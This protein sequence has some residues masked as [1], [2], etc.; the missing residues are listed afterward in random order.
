MFSA[1]CPFNLRPSH[2]SGR[3]RGLLLVWTLLG[4]VWMQ[5]HE[6]EPPIPLPD[7]LFQTVDQRMDVQPASGAELFVYRDR[8]DVSSDE[9]QAAEQR[10]QLAQAQGD[11][12]LMIE[13]IRTMGQGYSVRA[14]YDRAITQFGKGL[15][16]A[17]RLN[18]STQ[19]ALLLLNIARIHHLQRELNL[20][21]GYYH[22]ALDM[23]QQIAEERIEANAITAIGFIYANLGFPNLAL[24]H[25][26]R[27]LDMHKRTGQR[28]GEATTYNCMGLAYGVQF[29]A[30]EAILLFQN[31]IRIN[32]QLGNTGEAAR[33]LNNLCD[34]HL[35]IQGLPEKVLPLAARS[36]RYA[37]ELGYRQLI[38][39]AADRL[40]EANRALGRA[41]PALDMLELYHDMERQIKT[42]ENQR[43]SL[44]FE[45][46]QKA[47][48]DSLAYL[49]RQ[50]E[51]ELGHQR[52]ISL[53]NY[54]LLGV[55]GL[56]ILGVILLRNRQRS[57][58]RATQQALALQKA[59][60]RRLTELDQAK[61]QLY[62]NITHE[63]RTPLTIILGMAKKV[64]EAPE[65]WLAQGTDMIERN[66][67]QL[68]YLINQLLDLA[69]LEARQ[70][71]LQ[72]APLEVTAYISYLVES[73]Q[74]YAEMQGLTL[75][76]E[77]Q[78]NP[79]HAMLDGDR[80]KEVLSNLLAN[81]IKFTP[82]G[83]DI[84][85][86]THI[87]QQRLRVEVQDTGPGI[88]AESLDRVFD[89]FYQVEGGSTRPQEGTGIG[90]A[91]SRELAQLMDGSLTVT[92]QLGKGATFTLE[93]LLT[94]V[95]AE[96]SLS[97]EPAEVAQVQAMTPAKANT[98]PAAERAP[99]DVEKL[100]ILLVEDN[101]DVSAY[102]QSCLTPHYQVHLAS[103]GNEGLRKALAIVPDLIISDVMMP[104]M[105]GY[106]LCQRLKADLRA[107]HIPIILLTAR[108][109]ASSRLTGLRR[110]AD[111]YL[112]KPFEEEELHVQIDNLLS[113]RRKLQ[114][115]YTQS[116]GEESPSPDPVED[117]FI[118]RFRSL[119][120]EHIDDPQLDVPR[121]CKAMNLSRTPLHNK[122]KALTG[123]STTDFV[124][125]I[126][127]THA[128][129]LL[130]TTDLSIA[131][132]GYQTGFKHPTH[133]SRKFKEA[134][135]LT[136]KAYREETLLRP[137][138]GNVES[139]G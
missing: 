43:A 63:F 45:Y 106:E 122:L 100:R 78:A 128:Q 65:Q 103:N 18:D 51:L 130:K 30:E 105:D 123:L 77:R 27:A 46:T 92:S 86:R 107:S 124:R 40:Y 36:L 28:Q 7:T 47:V 131:E 120:M 114:A 97:P 90:L 39:D 56:G 66:S 82:R 104:E 88:P 62:N 126:R 139:K 67:Q 135:S 2:F 138:A 1:I 55:L 52:R 76:V 84:W 94:E 60:A 6:P 44:E 117:A 132:V 53:R 10:Y 11:S 9:L 75:H 21:F 121:I 61:A 54:L 20:A 95:D 25:Y 112:S 101:A 109:D 102:L 134:F 73:F 24:D 80:L 64:R 5:A 12:L 13:L 74:S 42:E 98:Q 33:S 79:T 111:A 83:G 41:Q 15:Q 4:Q 22:R 35:W 68:L 17:E 58:I 115:Y 133:F 113:S 32:E 31:S 34:T 37:Q 137:S 69:R 8:T 89:R 116:T 50:S 49:R 38:Q 70:L 108:A 127:L 81:A 119:V 85:V 29:C 99:K 118:S 3:E 57:R 125:H 23:A 91:L 26:Y 129:A 71:S 14:E 87:E 93:I 19:Q 110:G 48:Q 59:E 136:P 96:P 16:I 72:P